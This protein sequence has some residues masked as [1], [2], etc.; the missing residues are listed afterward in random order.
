MKKSSHYLTIAGR[1]VKSWMVTALLALAS[2][3]YV[4]LIFVPGQR[5]IAKVRSEI[6]EKQQHVMQSQQLGGPIRQAQLRLASTREYTADWHS[7]AP[8]SRDLVGVFAR[9]AEEAKAA[10]VQVKRLDP[11]PAVQH[12]AISEHPLVVIMEGSF[13]SVFDFV[14]RLERLPE[15]I[16]VRDLRMVRSDSSSETLMVELTL[17]IFTDRNE[18]AD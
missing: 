4:M 2:V 5:S 13:A 9:L 8:R 12:Q 17:T 3:G 18:N 1:P 7:A 10:G 15:T 14:R 11:Q 16:W 6:E